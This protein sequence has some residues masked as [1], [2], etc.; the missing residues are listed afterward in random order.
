[1]HQEVM[2]ELGV[3]VVESDQCMSGLKNLVLF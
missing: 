2:R 3:D 1:M